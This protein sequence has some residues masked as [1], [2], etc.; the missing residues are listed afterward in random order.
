MAQNSNSEWSITPLGTD[1]KARTDSHVLG[2]PKYTSSREETDPEFSFLVECN[3]NWARRWGKEQLNA[4]SWREDNTRS[5]EVDRRRFAEQQR[6]I[7]PKID[8]YELQQDNMQ[9][10][11]CEAKLKSEH[12]NKSFRG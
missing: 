8:K 2:V 3:L 7:R 4:K 11:R 1:Q 5:G 10:R 6:T 9:D 12:R